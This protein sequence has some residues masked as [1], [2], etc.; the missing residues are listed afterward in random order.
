MKVGILCYASVGGS[1]VVATELGK[2]LADRG[3][4]VHVIST[5]VPFRLGEFQPGLSFHP[6]Y[7][8]LPAVPRA[9]IRAVARQQ[10][11]ARRP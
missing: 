4:Q 9:A 11:R 8:D 7:A 5:D 10:G 3:H 1:G 6:Y 2:A